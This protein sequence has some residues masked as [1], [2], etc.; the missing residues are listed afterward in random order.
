[1]WSVIIWVT[2]GITTRKE[3]ILYI[4]EGSVHPRK[5]GEMQE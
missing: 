1:M 2:V 3:K 4:R 5:L